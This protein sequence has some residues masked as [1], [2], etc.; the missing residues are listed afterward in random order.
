MKAAGDPRE[1]L[2]PEHPDTALS[3]NNLAS[4]WD[5][6]TCWGAAAVGRWRSG[7]VYGPDIPT[8]RQ[9]SATSPLLDA[10][11]AEATALR[12]RHSLEEEPQLDDGGSWSWQWLWPAG[13]R[14]ELVAEHDSSGH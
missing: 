4:C 3:L 13:E 10:R 6:G 11:P 8:R 5:Q 9:A 2:G 14:R 12:T 1:V 7:K